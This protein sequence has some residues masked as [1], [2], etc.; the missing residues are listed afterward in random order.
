MNTTT[1]RPST[2]LSRTAERLS[3]LAGYSSA[4]LILAS[5]LVIGYGVV[6]RYVVGASTVWQTELSIYF[7]IYASFVGAAYGLRHGDHVAVDLVVVRLPEPVRNLIAFLAAVLGFLL[8]VVVAVLGFAFWWDVVESGRRSGTAWNPPLAYPYVILPVGMTVLALQYAV[9]VQELYEKARPR[10]RR[11]A[12]SSD[13]RDPA[14]DAAWRDGTPC[15]DDTEK[16]S[17]EGGAE[18]ASREDGAGKS[19]ENGEREEP[20]P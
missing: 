15:D 8:V 14:E 11:A 2:L 7:L 6:L 5:V 9:V 10:G 17:R 19:G 4:F 1:R 16:I 13:E 3:E 20:I 12:V 18:V